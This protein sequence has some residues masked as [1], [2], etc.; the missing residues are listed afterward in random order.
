MGKET[1]ISVIIADDE[2]SIRNGLLSVIPWETLDMNVMGVAKDGEEAW[3]FIQAV[4]PDIVITDIRMPRTTGLQLIKRCRT[5]G[6]STHFIILSG[7]DDFSYAQDAIRYGARAYVLKPLNQEEL[8]AELENLREEIISNPKSEDNTSMDLSGY[9][10]LSKKMF[11]NQL[12]NNEFHHISDIRQRIAQLKIEITDTPFQIIVISLNIDKEEQK[13]LLSAKVLAALS[14]M[15]TFSSLPLWKN[16]K[17]DLCLLFPIYSQTDEKLAYDTVSQCLLQLNPIKSCR[18]VAGIGTTVKALTDA[19]QSYH[20][21]LAALSYQLYESGQII[22]DQSV[23]C[24]Q[25]PT[26]CTSNIDNQRLVNAIRK[27]ERMLIESF[28]GTFFDSLLYVTMPPPSFIRGMSIYL[29]TDI[30]NTLRQLLNQ[31]L[32]LFAELPYIRINQ[33]ST[34]SQIKEWCT[35]LF[36][37]YAE[38]ISQHLGSRKDSVILE[39]K[40]YIQ[41]HINQKIQSEDIASIVNFSPSYFAIYFKSKTGV[42]FRDY[43]LNT[44]ME[45]AKYLLGTAD[46]NISEVAYAVGYDDYRSFYR[47]FKNHTGMTP[48]EYQANNR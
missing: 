9:L 31:D 24:T 2:S 1:R 27:N 6:L 17:S 8:I 30:Q 44:K 14:D 33:F 13:Q 18:I 7:Y 22:F 12:V 34:F 42:N 39:A 40:Q 20:T 45:H 35:S 11:F 41:E 48:S 26:V 4:N 23:I 16:N 28:C 38:K 43:V 15:D 36:L 5:A 10:E 25:S 32:Q 3:D 29:V 46:A 37:S 21:A 47:A 19:G